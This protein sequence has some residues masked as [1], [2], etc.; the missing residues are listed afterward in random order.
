MRTSLYT[1][2]CIGIRPAAVLTAVNAALAIPAA[3]IAV[4]R[5]DWSQS[6]IGWLASIWFVVLL[7]AL[8]LWI[9][10]GVLARENARGRHSRRRRRYRKGASMSRFIR[11]LL[12][13]AGCAAVPAFCAE[14]PQP[15]PPERVAN[16]WLLADTGSPLIPNSGRNLHEPSCAAVSYV[17]EKD[18][19]TSHAKVEKIVP[20]G[21]LRKVAVNV[22]A[23]MRFAP[24]KQNLG[25]TP[26]ATYVVLPFNLPDAN[27]PD[28]A[29][30]SERARVLAA[31][32]LEN[33]GPAAK[34]TV[35]P[36]R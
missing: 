17:I 30:R 34:E 32:R 36:I 22:V 12:T 4:A 25:K 6:D 2:L 5:G 15:I 14:T 18:G 9:S 11:G 19:S 28:A 35:V 1:I 10:P 23:A 24:A 7:L 26:V 27:S 33:F 16:Y 21:D 8:L 13:V 3:Y 31:C 29:Q 20:E